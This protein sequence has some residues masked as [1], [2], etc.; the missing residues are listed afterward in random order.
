MCLHGGLAAAQV[1]DVGAKTEW[2]KARIII[3]QPPSVANFWTSI[4]P[5]GNGYATPFSHLQAR[6]E[7][8]GYAQVLRKS[9]AKIF[10]V[11][12][13]LLAGTVDQNGNPVPGKALT[14]LQD[15]AKGFLELKPDDSAKADKKSL[16]EYKDKAI[17]SSGHGSLCN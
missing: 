2:D 13:V 3:M 15:F 4:F 12:D 17:R 5:V 16:D 6:K 9:G 11:E 14:Q 7:L 1:T 10:L 8:M